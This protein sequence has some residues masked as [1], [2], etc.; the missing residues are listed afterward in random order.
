MS[1]W[2][3]G[4]LLGFFFLVAISFSVESLIFGV[5]AFMKF[6]SFGPKVECF[7]LIE[8]FKFRLAGC[9]QSCRIGL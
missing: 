8:F 3:T 6:L 4:K 7:A 2:V 9:L 1:F 5:K